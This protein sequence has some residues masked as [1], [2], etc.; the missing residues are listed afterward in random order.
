[1][2]EKT[3]P[4]KSFQLPLAAGTNRSS[5]STANPATSDTMAAVRVGL[6]HF[7]HEITNPL[8]M[9]Y[10]TV[11]LIEQELPKTNGHVDPFLTKAIP[12]L[13]G[14][15]D[16]MISLI[17]SLRS[18]LEC[19]WSINPSIE[20]V[21][22]PFLIDEALE[23]ESARF[24]TNTV[25]IRQ[26]FPTDLPAIKASKKLLNQAILNLLRN[27]ADAMPQGGTLR[28]SAGVREDRIYLE[29]ADSGGGI[30]A[31]L[32]V[33]Q[34]FATTK[35]QGLGLGLAITRHVIETHGGTIGYRSEPGKG[36]TFCL[37]FPLAQ[38]AE[39]LSTTG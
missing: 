28:I 27:A 36:T 19:L 3:V 35:A 4:D 39:K 12:Q 8:H 29:L 10:S 26:N 15:V 16:Q 20:S 33:F 18:Q 22:L 7:I 31:N 6:A 9:V 5:E 23:T 21:D 2:S 25:L 37:T 13:K 32:D 17:G 14:E 1:M 24:Q 11:G 30:P 38:A 34:P